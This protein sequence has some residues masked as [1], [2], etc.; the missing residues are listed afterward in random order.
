MAAHDSHSLRVGQ[1]PEEARRRPAG[2]ATYRA[3]RPNGGISDILPSSAT[4]AIL[5]FAMLAA[6]TTLL[7]AIVV[8]PAFAQEYTVDEGTLQ[9]NTSGGV[10]KPGESLVISGGGFEP[11]ARPYH[12]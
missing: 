12:H 2:A 11:G 5:R 3:T 1:L 10:I 9:N 7:F 8:Q 6:V 4:T